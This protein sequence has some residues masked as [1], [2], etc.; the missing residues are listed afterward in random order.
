MAVKLTKEFTQLEKSAVKLTV[1]IEK[2]EVVDFYNSTVAKYVKN[3]Q[4]PGFR[5]GHVPASVLERKYGD[6]LKADTLSELIDQSLGDIF[7]NETENRP[8]PYAQPVLDTLPEFDKTKAIKMLRASLKRNTYLLGREWP[9]KNIQRKVLAEQF[10]EGDETGELPDCKF[11]CFDGKVKLLY[12]ISHSKAGVRQDYFDEDFNPLDLQGLYPNS[13][14]KPQKPHDFELMK[15]LAEKLSKGIPH[16]RMDFFEANKRVYFS[17][18]TFFPSGGWAAFHPEEYGRF[19]QTRCRI[20]KFLCRMWLDAHC[21][22][23]VSC[24]PAIC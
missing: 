12:L 10:I 7:D 19:V 20:R 17:E 22:C 3:A 1:T 15:N 13:L 23:F 16:V 21:V 9:Y 4:I 14:I 18:F 24:L 6:S 5:K 2:K 8:L 11:F